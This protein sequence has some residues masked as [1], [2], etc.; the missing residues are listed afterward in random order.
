MRRA[1]IETL[2][3]LADT[4]DRILLI[5]G[6]LGFSVVEPFADRHPN[7]FVNVGV[8]EQN[9]VGVATG[10]AE[11]GFIPFAYSIAT[12]A[13]LRAHEF[14][15]NGPV[16]HDL[17]VRVVGVGGGFEYGTAGFT[18][19]AID[20]LATMRSMPRLL[21]LAPAD[22]QQARAALKATWDR[23]GAV[24]YRLGKHEGT[25]VAGLNGGFEVGAVSKVREGA[26][27]AIIATG[28]ISHEAVRAAEM[29]D[30]GVAAVH[31]AATLS[32][33]PVDALLPILTRYRLVV[34]V[35]A[36]HTI[37]GLASLVSE[38]VAANG[39]GTRVIGCGISASDAF[40]SGSE[41]FLNE[42]GGIDAEGIAARI[43]ASLELVS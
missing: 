41:Q 20:D 22:A 10:L 18:H 4:D 28:G 13:A 32:P 30:D 39:L 35:E 5:T 2:A 33:P 24:Y 37:G 23:S 17:P 14:I 6:D 11:A 1:F 40:G 16:L 36:H 25:T 26:D 29:L 3:D 7:R 9:M 19:H 43:R 27:L 21:V 8:A 12:F 15:R 31:I 38:V 42:Q 34:T